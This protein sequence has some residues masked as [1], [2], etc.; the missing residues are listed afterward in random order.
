MGIKNRILYFIFVIK[1]NYFYVNN[2]KIHNIEKDKNIIEYLENRKISTLEEEL[3]II[4]PI[5]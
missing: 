3:S 1:L 5:E 2:I 4:S